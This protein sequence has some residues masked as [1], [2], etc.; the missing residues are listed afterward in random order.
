MMYLILKL[1]CEGWSDH[2]ELG[3][4]KATNSGMMEVMAMNSSVV[5][6]KAMHSDVVEVMPSGWA[7]AVSHML[8]QNQNQSLTISSKM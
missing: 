7:V 4:V 8:I 3:V 5:E 6:L 1:V 2:M